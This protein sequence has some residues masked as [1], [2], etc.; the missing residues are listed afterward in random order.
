MRRKRP[1]AAHSTPR[2]VDM[3]CGISDLIT[4]R[5]RGFASAPDEAALT[6]FVMAAVD[7]EGNSSGS[8]YL[9]I[10]GLDA[11]KLLTAHL[12]DFIMKMESEGNH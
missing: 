1:D 12:Q 8:T 6:L 7:P 2:L 3:S 5:M 4:A 9:Q 10:D 11:L